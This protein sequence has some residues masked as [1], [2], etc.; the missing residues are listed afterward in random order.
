MSHCA[1]LA[2]GVPH[3][4]GKECIE[5][6]CC[7]RNVLIQLRPHAVRLAST[8]QVVDLGVHGT[9]CRYPIADEA[10]FS[11]R[12]PLSLHECSYPE[13]EVEV[14]VGLVTHARVLLPGFPT[15]IALEALQP[16]WPQVTDAGVVGYFHR[17]RTR[18]RRHDLLKVSSQRLQTRGV[19]GGP[20]FVDPIEEFE[21]HPHAHLELGMHAATVALPE[22][23]PPAADSPKVIIAAA[24]DLTLPDDMKMPKGEDPIDNVEQLDGAASSARTLMKPADDRELVKLAKQPEETAAAKIEQVLKCDTMAATDQDLDSTATL[25]GSSVPGWVIPKNTFLMTTASVFEALPRYQDR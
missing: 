21:F 12:I 22:D 8:G 6:Q 7:R 10:I 1:R 13:M 15:D 17:L 5:Q 24:I 3:G 14:P 16:P 19:K 9:R 25:K 11:A 2:Y 20:A 23:K 4:V 18:V